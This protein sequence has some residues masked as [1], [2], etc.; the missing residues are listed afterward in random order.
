MRSYIDLLGKELLETKE[1][2]KDFSFFN[3]INKLPP[4]AALFDFVEDMLAERTENMRNAFSSSKNISTDDIVFR[5][6]VKLP[7]DTIEIIRPFLEQIFSKALKGEYFSDSPVVIRN[8]IA[9]TGSRGYGISFAYI[10][11]LLDDPSV[12]KDIKVDLA[13]L[14]SNISP[15]RFL[16]YFNTKSDYGQYSYLIPAYI[17]MYE[18]EN[19]VK[20]LEILK[21]LSDKPKDFTYYKSPITSVL[22]KILIKKKDYP[23][24]LSLC[25]QMPQWVKQE[26]EIILSNNWFTRNN[27]KEELA[28]Y[29]KAE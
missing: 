18:Y 1:Q 3:F 24:Y 9:L 2:R 21:T 15:E 14:F 11:N 16:S 4:E 22:G 10:R 29:E 12:S 28:E 13:Y 23:A 5:E 26:F 27:V 8:V 7:H 17:S 6:M 19:P 25:L 20:A